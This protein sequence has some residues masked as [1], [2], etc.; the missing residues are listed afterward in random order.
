MNLVVTI[1]QGLSYTQNN[2]L[3]YYPSYLFLNSTWLFM[4]T[5]AVNTKKETRLQGLSDLQGGFG[6]GSRILQGR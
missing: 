6:A 3:S 5:R 1:F 2:K 4:I